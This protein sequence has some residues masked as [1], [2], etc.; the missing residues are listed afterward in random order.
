MRRRGARQAHDDRNLA[1]MLTPAERKEKKTRKLVGAAAEG[2]ACPVT[3]YRIASLANTQH[4]FK[5]RVN[6]VVRRPA[7]CVLAQQNPSSFRPAHCAASRP[8][9]SPSGGELRPVRGRGLAHLAGSC[10]YEGAGLKGAP[11]H[12]ECWAH[13]KQRPCPAACCAVAARAANA[14]GFEWGHAE[15]HLSALAGAAAD[16]RRGGRVPSSP[17]AGSRAW[18]A[19][20]WLRTAVAGAQELHLTGIAVASDGMA[21]VVA[22]G[23]AKAQKKYAKLLLHRIAWAAGREDDADAAGAPGI[24]P[25]PRRCALPCCGRPLWIHQVGWSYCLA[26]GA[27]PGTASP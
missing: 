18:Q 14:D 23:G 27:V 22:E 10:H 16:R 15:C 25:G 8:R 2:E 1:R 7:R 6:A 4:R 11:R 21:V 20:Q 26:F 19:L 17:L 9:W 3:C 13:L 5:V 24:P 12:S